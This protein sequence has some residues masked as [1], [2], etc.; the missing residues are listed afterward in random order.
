MAAALTVSGFFIL[1]VLFLDVMWTT[2]GLGGGILTKRFSFRLY[3]LL[4]KIYALH[5]SRL[6][7]SWIAVIT[8]IMVF[9][10]WVGM[11]WLGWALVFSAGDHVVQSQSLAPAG[12]PERIYFTGFT[13]FTLGSG[14]F[15]PQGAVYQILTALASLMGLFMITFGVTFLVPVVQA[16][17]QKRRVAVT[18]ASLGQSGQGVLLNAWNGRDCSVLAQHLLSLMPSLSQLEQQHLTYPMLHYFHGGRRSE[19]LGIGI[20]VLDEALTI[21]RYG[22]KDNGGLPEGIHNP[23]RQVI[24][25]FLST[26]KGNFIEPPQ[27]DPPP[28]A[29]DPLRSSGLPTLSDEEF[30]RHLEGI[31]ERRRL[32]LALLRNEGW[33]WTD[34]ETKRYGITPENQLD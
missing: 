22:L 28:P 17:T 19:S 11:L 9:T 6:F 31:T 4:M 13:I 10:V 5:R 33:E 20:T 25:Q 24:T 21:L 32:L 1:V 23:A 26:L 8:L 2:M 3:L 15:K 29:L 16:A 14:D 30:G 7:I 34:T 18:I 27:E 12:I